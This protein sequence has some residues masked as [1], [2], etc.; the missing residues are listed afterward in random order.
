MFNPFKWF[1]RII[2]WYSEGISKKAK[3][4]IALFILFFMIGV[5][6][7]GYKINDYFEHDP[8]ACQLC[9]V[10][11]YAQERW[12]QSKHNV[13]TCHDCHHSTKKEQVVQLYRF[14]FLGQ[15]KGRTETRKDYSA[16]QAMY[17][18]PLGR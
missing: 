14:V 18:L 16:I 13:V 12:A 4:I 10:H 17:V 1:D 6:F 11:D 15:K 2:K 3:I 5:G 7:A 9:H 8:D